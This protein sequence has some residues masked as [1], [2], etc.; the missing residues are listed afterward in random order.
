MKEFYRN[1]LTGISTISKGIFDS[2]SLID[3]FYN[4][5]NRRAEPTTAIFIK[6]YKKEALR[7]FPQLEYK[8]FYQ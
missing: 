4:L 3:F 5:F 2:F 1:G 7:F 6:Y 8:Y